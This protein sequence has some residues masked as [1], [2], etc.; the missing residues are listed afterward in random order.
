MNKLKRILALLGV[1]LLLAMYASTLVF[2][3]MDHPNAGGM[4]MGSIY[5]TI[6]IPVFLYAILLAA[7][8]LGKNSDAKTNEQE[9]NERK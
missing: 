8:V 6:V 3:L 2:A 4:L 9:N 1:I 5:S 7:K